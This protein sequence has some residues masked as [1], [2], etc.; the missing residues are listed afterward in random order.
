MGTDATLCAKCGGTFSVTR[1]HI[2]GKNYH[3]RCAFMSYPSHTQEDCGRLSAEIERL[4]AAL[5]ECADDLEASV[6]AE[7]Q[8]TLDYPSQRRKF[9]RDMEPVRKARA[10]LGADQ[11]AAQLVHVGLDGQPH[12]GP[13]AECKQCSET[14]SHEA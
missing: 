12:G 9:E 6:K 5:T 2:D 1:V 3:E 10:L 4:R 11:P 14:N 13:R 7:Y 8:G